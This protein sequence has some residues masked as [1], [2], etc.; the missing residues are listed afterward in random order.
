MIAHFVNNLCF[1]VHDELTNRELDRIYPLIVDQKWSDALAA[2]NAL[3]VKTPCVPLAILYRSIC[4]SNLKEFEQA[5]LDAKLALKFAPDS[6][7]PYAVLVDV[8][9]D[10]QSWSEVIE[11]CNKAIECGANDVGIFYS[12]ACTVPTFPIRRS[13]E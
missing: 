12:R 2:L 4:L 10:R 11:F 9:V 8:A 5:E 3:Y 7:W 13:F 6:F 1:A